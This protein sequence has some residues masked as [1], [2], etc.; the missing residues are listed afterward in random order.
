V[1][2]PTP[3]E[4]TTGNEPPTTGSGVSRYVGGAVALGVLFVVLAIQNSERV[5]IDL[6][7]WHVNTPLYGIAVACALLGAA[8]AESVAGIWRHRRH[9]HNRE[10]VELNELRHSR[11]SRPSRPERD[12]HEARPT[13]VSDQDV[14]NVV[15]KP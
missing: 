1:P 7:F 12:V 3:R 14:E 4:V 6:L 13:S 8:V 2:R 15:T 5:D 9:L 10:R 11:H